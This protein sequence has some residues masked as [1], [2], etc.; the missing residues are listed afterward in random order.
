MNVGDLRAH[1]LRL[2]AFVAPMFLVSSVDLIVAA[3][4]AGLVGTYPTANSRTLE[5]L[6][7]SLAAITEGIKT[8]A[9]QKAAPLWAVNLNTH[10][11]NSRL[12]G[13]LAVISRFKP[14]IVVTALGSPKPVM[15]TVKGYGGIVIADV[16]NM[17][18]AKKAIAAGADGLACVCAGS[19]GHT[20]H[21]SPFAF[22][23]AVREIFD[24]I[25]VLGGGIADGWGIAGAIA[26]GA[27]FVYLGTRFIA[28]NESAADERHKELVVACTTTDLLISDAITGA[29]VSWLKPSV[30]A[31]V[32]ETS[33]KGPSAIDHDSNAAPKKRW[34]EIFSAGQGLGATK[35][36]ESVAG[37][38]DELERGWKAARARFAAS[39]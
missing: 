20:G 26:A 8:S 36:V 22:V 18:L 12:A 23:S 24:G 10:S 39:Y 1:P 13:D 15:E 6:E 25:I 37:I 33:A 7:I 30:P 19:G 14:P 29:P 17:A 32:F 31:S 11:S 28:S 4:A 35:S 9:A 38:V 3:A 34:K 16:T 2:P 21:M 27:D 5:Q